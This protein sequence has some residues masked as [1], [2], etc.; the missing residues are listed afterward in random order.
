MGLNVE[1]TYSNI[2][3]ILDVLDVMVLHQ[4]L[5]AG[6]EAKP[7]ETIKIIVN[8]SDFTSSEVFF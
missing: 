4:N 5:Q 3:T 6:S 2:S 7:G 1:V 8:D